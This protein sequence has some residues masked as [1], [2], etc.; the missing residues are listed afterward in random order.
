MKNLSFTAYQRHFIAADASAMAC[1]I[2]VVFATVAVRSFICPS[3]KL[4]CAKMVLV[5]TRFLSAY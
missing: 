5:T 2:K 4:R 3:A 1:R